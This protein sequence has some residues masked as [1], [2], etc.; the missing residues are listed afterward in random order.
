M[1]SG[2]GVGAAVAIVYQTSG[3]DMEKI[4]L[5]VNNLISDLGGMLCDGAKGDAPLRLQVLQ[6][7]LSEAPIWL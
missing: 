2:V 4:T 7:L 1:L 6:I 5:A 3:A